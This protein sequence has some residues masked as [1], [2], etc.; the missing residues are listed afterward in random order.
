MDIN[1]RLGEIE[2]EL[3]HEETH[4]DRDLEWLALMQQHL[5]VSPEQKAMAMQRV[6]NC[7]Q[8]HRNRVAALTRER[9]DLLVLAA[10]N[11]RGRNFS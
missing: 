6:R 2:R 11:N 1:R 8:T 10:A 4:L 5:D 3:E 7:I 9:E